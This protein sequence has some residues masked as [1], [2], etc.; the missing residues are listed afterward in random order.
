MITL[1]SFAHVVVTG[2]IAYDDIMNFPGQFADHFHPEMLHQINISF[3][4]DRLDKYFGGTATNIAYNITRLTKK[5]IHIMGALGQD[6]SPISSFFTR[7]GIDFSGSVIC[8][9][10]FTSTGKVMTDQSD[11]QI[12]GYYYGA[13]ARGHLVDYTAVKDP[14]FFVIS[15]NHKDAFLHT[16][17]YCIQ[18]K[19]PYMYDPGMVLTWIEDKELSEGIRHAGYIVGND[20]EIAQMERRLKV[21]IRELC[22][23]ETGVITTMGAKGVQYEDS[24]QKLIMPAYP[25]DTIKDP[26]GAGDAW[27]GGFLAGLLEGRSIEDALRFGNALAS[28]AIESSGTVN[29]APTPEQILARAGTM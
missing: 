28:F 26:T 19:I 8:N 3:V 2:S 9:D 10:L 11:N 14:A 13:G 17:T 5:H 15:A 23:P 21:R 6:H 7:S 12:W 24:S 29:H 22:P 25:L 16:Q 18:K 20:Y 1:S 4:V 27:R